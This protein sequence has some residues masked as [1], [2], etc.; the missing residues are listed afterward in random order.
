MVEKAQLKARLRSLHGEAG[1]L[2]DKLQHARDK[3]QH[4]KLRDRNRKRAEAEHAAQVENA[5]K[6]RR[7]NESLCKK[8]RRSQSMS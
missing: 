2:R 6:K 3:L 8:R 4:K 1:M 7:R 5:K